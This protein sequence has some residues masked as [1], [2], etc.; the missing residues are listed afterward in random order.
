MNSLS[1]GTV[2]PVFK[3]H[4]DSFVWK[5]EK[6]KASE[7]DPPPHPN[8]LPRKVYKEGWTLLKKNM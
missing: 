7:K 2:E 8:P 3:E 1:L 5:C 4:P 6:G